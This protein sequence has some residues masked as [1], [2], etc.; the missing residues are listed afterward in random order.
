ML[1]V[2]AKAL[3]GHNMMARRRHVLDVPDSADTT[4]QVIMID[5][6]WPFG[7]GEEAPM[8]S[9]AITRGSDD[10]YR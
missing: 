1:E 8:F 3:T 4:G 10:H 5:C 9:A 7:G 2:R 6:G